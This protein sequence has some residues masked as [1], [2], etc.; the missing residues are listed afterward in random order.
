MIA[1]CMGGW[2]PL[3]DKCLHH[4]DPT[5]RLDPV[6]RK[7]EPGRERKTFFVQ[8][9]EAEIGPAL[10]QLINPAGQVIAIDGSSIRAWARIGGY[11]PTVENLL[12]NEEAGWRVVP[13]KV[14]EAA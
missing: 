9:I 6:E 3:R 13:T 10:W 11:K 4:I 1:P 2:C 12:A 14:K 5:N 7:C 8:A